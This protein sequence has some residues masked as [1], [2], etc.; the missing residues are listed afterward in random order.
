MLHYRILGIFSFLDLVRSSSHA[1]N[2]TSSNFNHHLNPTEN[3]SCSQAFNEKIDSENRSKLKKR[4]LSESVGI[5]DDDDLQIS[6][7]SFSIT[8]D[9]ASSTNSDDTQRVKTSSN[10]HNFEDISK[11]KCNI[12]PDLNED[13]AYYNCTLSPNDNLSCPSASSASNMHSKQHF[14]E[15]SQFS[16]CSEYDFVIQDT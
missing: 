3:Y 8:I 2:P 10:F 9:S 16:T 13:L 7:Y 1:S 6:N 12:F 5:D 15:K 14:E 11:S 4:K